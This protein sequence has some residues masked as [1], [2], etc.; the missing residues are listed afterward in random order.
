MAYAAHYAYGI[1]TA[2]GLNLEELGV[3]R[4]M[5]VYEALLLEYNSS[6]LIFSLVDLAEYSCI[7]RVQFEFLELGEGH[8][9]EDANNVRPFSFFLA[10]PTLCAVGMR[11]LRNDLIDAEHFWF[12]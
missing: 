3:D 8:T 5:G 7:S 10:K 12:S 2:K 9:L 1:G 4:N 6:S 11:Y